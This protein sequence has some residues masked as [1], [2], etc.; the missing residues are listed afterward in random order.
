MK[1]SSTE[2]IYLVVN[3]RMASGSFEFDV[4]VVGSGIAGLTAAARLARRGMRVAVLEQ[5]ALAGGY[6]TS[7]TRVSRSD[8]ETRRFTF[9][10]GV[11]DVSGANPGQPVARLLDELGVHDR[12][13]WLPIEHEVFQ[14]DLRFRI[15]RAPVKLT[16]AL[17][18][19]FPAERVGIEALLDR[20]AA[21]HEE[22]VVSGDG[23]RPETR[24]WID[25]TWS[26]LVQSF[27]R[28]RRLRTLMHALCGYLT[29]DESRAAAVGLS[30]EDRALAPLVPLAPAPTPVTIRVDAGIAVG[31]VGAATAATVV[32]IDTK[33]GFG[34][35]PDTRLRVALVGFDEAQ[36]STLK[37]SL[38]VFGMLSVVMAEESVLGGSAE[39]VAAVL[40][41]GD[42][43]AAARTERL[44]AAGPPVLVLGVAR[45]EEVPVLV[46]AGASD[47]IVGAIVADAVAKKITRLGRRK[48]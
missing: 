43:V 47:V 42:A 22:N 26:S 10:A 27:V 45:A 37:P 14:P 23:P 20:V 16:A 44:R 39:P 36:V 17:V 24:R 4:V 7:W 5:H 3:I 40:I 12:V 30:R 18:A 21:I 19:A 34:P 25:A 13:E 31:V 29:H 6:C 8:G 1:P 2:S 11:H 9:D 48:R 28:D 35:A 32:G 46:R 33:V 15:P 41:P 38:A